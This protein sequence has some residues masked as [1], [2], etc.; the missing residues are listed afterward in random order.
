MTGAAVRVRLPGN[1]CGGFIPVLL[2]DKSQFAC[3]AVRSRIACI[4]AS[5]DAQID[6]TR[7]TFSTR[8]GASAEKTSI[9]FGS[10]SS[11]GSTDESTS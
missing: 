3:N 2:T 4:D 5:Y 8:R 6:R 1:R 7:I 9:E 11:P 10:M